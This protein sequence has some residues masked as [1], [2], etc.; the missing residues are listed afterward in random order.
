MASRPRYQEPATTDLLR[1]A[2]RSLKRL[3]A[4]STVSPSEFVI[5]LRSTSV[6]YVRQLNAV[7][8]P[9]SPSS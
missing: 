1:L 2:Q 9:N 8:E 3:G 7:R 5:T 6:S 4:D